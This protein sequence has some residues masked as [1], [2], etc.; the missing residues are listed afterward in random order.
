M[1]KREVSWVTKF[2]RQSKIEKKRHLIQVYLDKHMTLAEV[3]EKLD[4]SVSTLSAYI[5]RNEWI[6]KPSRGRLGP[7]SGTLTKAEE[8]HVWALV[9]GYALKHLKWLRARF[10]TLA[11]LDDLESEMAVAATRAL[12]TYDKAHGASFDTYLHFVCANA[13]KDYQRALWREI[14]EY[15]AREGRPFVPT[16]ED[17]GGDG[18]NELGPDVDLDT[19]TAL[20]EDAP[21]D[22]AQAV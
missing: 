11:N 22:M 15:E 8:D 17:E 16:Q 14:R 3:A 19:I 18:L 1:A 21:G 20:N 2:P 4:V 13:A 10:G 5:K 12:K 6:Q 9:K 7:V